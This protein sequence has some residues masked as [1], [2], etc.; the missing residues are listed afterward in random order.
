M[1]GSTEARLRNRLPVYRYGDRRRRRTVRSSRSPRF[2]RFPLERG[3]LAF[4]SLFSFFFLCP[5]A[6]RTARFPACTS[7]AEVLDRARRKRRSEVSLPETDPACWTTS[8]LRRRRRRHH[9][10]FPPPWSSSWPPRSLLLSSHPSFPRWQF[11][12]ARKSSYLPCTLFSPFPSLSACRSAASVSIVRART[13]RIFRHSSAPPIGVPFSTTFR[14]IRHHRR[15]T[16]RRDTTVTVSTNINRCRTRDRSFGYRCKRVSVTGARSFGDYVTRRIM[17]HGE[18]CCE[19]R[20]TD[21]SDIPGVYIAEEMSRD[22][23]PWNVTN[24]FLSRAH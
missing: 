19:L 21:A 10:P 7:A 12:S 13:L 17:Y 15:D 24:S 20:G 3:E 16:T 5:G 4:F 9:H 6:W 14:R 2:R 23:T 8:G 22:G 11:P 1:D 18:N